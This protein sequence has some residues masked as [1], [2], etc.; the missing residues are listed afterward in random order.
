MIIAVDFDGTLCKE[1][2][3]YIG[4]P[5]QDIIDYIKM[6]KASGDKIILWT[7]RY[8]KQLKQAIKW[9]KEQGIEFD[10]INDNIKEQKKL[11]H[12][13][14]RKVYADIY[15]DDK[16]INLKGMYENL[17]RNTQTNK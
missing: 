14:C 4:E 12:N 1:S 7:C 6:L 2:F 3:P 8:G 9:C 10:A 15:I 11:Y 13:N 17:Y 16:A 5:N